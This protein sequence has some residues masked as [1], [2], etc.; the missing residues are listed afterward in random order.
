MK[1]DFLKINS[2]SEL[3]TF[4]GVPLRTFAYTVYRV[5]QEDNYKTFEIHKRNG[6]LRKINAPKGAIRKL[7]TQIKVALEEVYTPRYCTHGYIERRGIKSNAKR[8]CRKKNVIKLDIKDFFETINFGRVYGMFM[9]NPFNFNKEVASCLAKICCY[10][11]CLPTGACTSPVISNIICFKLDNKL[12][13]YAKKNNCYYTRYADDLTFSTN[14]KDV[15]GGLI[16]KKNKLDL[17]F[18][19]VKEENSIFK[20]G[21]DIRKIIE[22]NGFAIN[23]KKSKLI[24]SSSRQIIAGVVV[25]RKV[26][27]PKEQISQLKGI[28]HAWK[29][30]DIDS[31]AERYF[32][33]YDKRN[34]PPDRLKPLLFEQIVI[35]KLLHIRH[36]KG[37]HSSVYQKLSLKLSEVSSRFNAL[38]NEVHH[39]SDLRI[40]IYT[41]GKTDIHHLSSALSNLKDQEQFHNLDV[42]FDECKSFG[43]D[44]NLINKLD[45]MKGI[46]QTVLTIGLFDNDVNMSKIAEKSGDRTQDIQ[47]WSFGLFS[48][49]LPVPSHRESLDWKDV[50]MEMNYLDKDLKRLDK[51]GRRLFTLDEFASDGKLLAQPMIR[52]SL[53]GKKACKLIDNGVLAAMYDTTG[54]LHSNSVSLT[55]SD[56]ATNIRSSIDEFRDIDFSGYTALFHRIEE[57]QDRHLRMVESRKRFNTHFAG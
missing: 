4:F 16:L 27:V 30:Y 54:K 6:G 37:I 34:R 26:S 46:D 24:P 55:K 1:N 50:C 21:K 44:S 35:G 25:N 28:I 15:P 29:K 31:V 48:M 38:K 23:S 18:N 9:S 17:L 14:Q 13:E 39:R 57:I 36:I 8:H 12:I 41:E 56:F 19:Y 10:Q 32:E 49:T 47:N 33:K 53:Y 52:Y 22:D 3:A 42:V 7:Q 20:A 43:G 11:G 2:R 40:R 45:G 51:F 5:N